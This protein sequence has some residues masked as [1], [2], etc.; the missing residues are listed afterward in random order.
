MYPNK[1]QNLSQI[2]A[3]TRQARNQN[4]RDFARELGVSQNMVSLWER[5]A[6]DV[7]G[8]RLQA[9]FCDKRPWV[10]AMAIEI[11]VIKFRELL[12]AL[13]PAIS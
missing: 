12:Q 7:D 8:E 3:T 10:A 6:S 4:M 1:T 9:W 13:R 5:G 11:Q 2:I